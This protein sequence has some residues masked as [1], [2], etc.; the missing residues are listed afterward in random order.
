[1]KSLLWFLSTCALQGELFSEKPFLESDALHTLLTLAWG[2]CIV[3]GFVPQA[4]LH[5][6]LEVSLAPASGVLSLVKARPVQMGPEG[7]VSIS[8]LSLRTCEHLPYDWTGNTSIQPAFILPRCYQPSTTT[9]PPPLVCLQER[10]SLL[11]NF[12]KQTSD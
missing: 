4:G 7:E 5:E 1:M 6:P 8:T 9:P 11:L 2:Q 10:D 12:K 3:G